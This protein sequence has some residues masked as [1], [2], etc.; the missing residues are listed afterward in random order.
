MKA[1][2]RDS[3]VAQRV[4]HLPAMRETWVRSLGQEDPL[5]KELATHSSILA[6]RMPWTVPT[7]GSQRV[8]ESD[9]TEQL[10]CHFQ[11]KWKSLSHVQFFATP[12]TI[13]SMEFSRPESWNGQPFPSPGHLPNPG[14]KPKS[15]ALQADSLPTE[16]SGRARKE[17]LNFFRHFLFRIS[18][19]FK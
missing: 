15:A 19:V 13:Q 17:S 18:D 10:H 3:L 1:K 8:G 4:K 16:L 2:W 14:I 11:V 6:W 12:W 7:T 5:E 9:T